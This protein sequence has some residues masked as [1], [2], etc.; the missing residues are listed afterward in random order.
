MPEGEDVEGVELEVLPSATIRGRVEDAQ[1]NP[2]SS[3]DVRAEGPGRSRSSDQVADDGTFEIRGLRGGEY[4]VRAALNW[5]DSLRK[6]GTTD[7][8]VQGE[9]VE[10]EAGESAEVTIVVESRNLSISGVVVDDAGG[11][12]PDAFVRAERVSDAQGANAKKA[13]QSA[14]WGGWRLGRRPSAPAR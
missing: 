5:S 8:D 3:A 7:D 12:V 13:I 9:L 11:P 14:R 1:G 4:R 6:P 2:I 10:V